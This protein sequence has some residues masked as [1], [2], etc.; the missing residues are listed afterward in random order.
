MDLV[1]RDVEEFV[2]ELVHAF[3]AERLGKR[4]GIDNVTERHGHLLSFAFE[5]GSGRQDEFG[6][7]LRRKI[8]KKINLV[9][10]TGYP[11]RWTWAPLPGP[12]R[13]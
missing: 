13:Q 4:R 9:A 3:R 8:T 11:R 6:K 2:Q 5:R 7:V 10:P 1:E 12:E